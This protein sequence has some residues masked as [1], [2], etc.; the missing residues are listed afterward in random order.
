MEMLE[1]LRS[2]PVPPYRDRRP[3]PRVIDV[4]GRTSGKPRPFG[5]NVTSIDG[6]LYICSATRARDWVRNLVA[7]GR[8]RVE[9]DGPTGAH[10]E[11]A[12][13]LVEGHEAA[14]ALATYLPQ[15]DYRDPQLPFDPGAP[16]DEIERHT[17]FTAVFRLDGE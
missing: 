17:G 3:V 15:I 11:R 16:L 13:V 9:R 1:Q 7:A 5:V 2:Q 12:P 14:V 10:V 8:C 6:R 4:A